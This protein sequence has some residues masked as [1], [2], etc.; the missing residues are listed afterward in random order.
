[1]APRV[2]VICQDRGPLGALKIYG[3]HRKILKVPLH[4]KK[5]ER[6]VFAAG[7]RN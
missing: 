2:T 1:M 3:D 4:R 5:I 7:C 6:R